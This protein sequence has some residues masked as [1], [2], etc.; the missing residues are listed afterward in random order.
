[1]EYYVVSIADMSYLINYHLRYSSSQKLPGLST[2]KALS[3][4]HM[5]S[6]PSMKPFLIEKTHKVRYT[7]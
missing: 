7:L 2:E 6:N 5:T 3:T 4:S 1:M